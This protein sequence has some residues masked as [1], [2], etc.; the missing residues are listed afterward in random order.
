[1]RSN[2]LTFL[3]ATAHIILGLLAF[4]LLSLTFIETLKKLI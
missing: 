3:N 4:I 2:Q 1:M